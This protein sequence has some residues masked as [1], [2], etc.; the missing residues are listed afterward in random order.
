M[1][2]DTV[3]RCVALV[4]AVVLIGIPVYVAI[5]NQQHPKPLEWLKVYFP[6]R[7]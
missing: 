5:K 7:K 1:N 3:G 4:L 6:D 2:N